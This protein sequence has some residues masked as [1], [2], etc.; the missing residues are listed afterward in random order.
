MQETEIIIIVIAGTVLVLLMGVF[1]FLFLF[2][3]QKSHHKYVKE[4]EALK[5]RYEQT[6]LQTKLEIQEQTLQQ[7]SY[8]L[9][10]NLG[11]IASLIKINLNT[12]VLSDQQKT[13]KKI[14]VTKDLTRQLIADLK[15][16]SVS[17]GSD[18]IS[19]KGLLS[20]LRMETE[21]LNRMEQFTVTLDAVSELPFIKEDTAVIL[22]RMTQEIL[23]NAVKHSAANTITITLTAAENS[24]ELIVADNGIGFEKDR[25]IRESNGS[26]LQHLQE[27]AR[28]INAILDIETAASNGTTITIL[29]LL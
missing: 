6:F 24:V 22:Y 25:N 20:A 1:L 14:E 19:R 11:Q 9:H 7:I 3:Y 27:R 2:L 5:T 16:L 21:R 8:E 23:N 12:I 18:W 15:S 28:L 26:G 29:L 17:L 13:E 4:T 10:D